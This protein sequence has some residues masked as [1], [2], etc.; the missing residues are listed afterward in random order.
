MKKGLFW[1]RE[2]ERV[3]CQLCP[4]SCLLAAGQRGMCFGREN[5]EGELLAATYGRVSSCAVD[6]VEKKP[7]YHFFPGSLVLSVGT[8][9]CNFSC[10]FCQNWH[11]S[12]QEAPTE[13]MSPEG[14]WSWLWRSRRGIRGWSGLPIRIQNPWFGTSTSKKQLP[15]P[16][17]GPCQC[18]GH[19]WVHQA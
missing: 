14:L 19:Q 17:R 11:I 2:G 5:R 12:Q 3:R 15:W 6:P 18:S 4:H 1:Q 13:Y 7:L 16:K 10:C 9:G 8:V